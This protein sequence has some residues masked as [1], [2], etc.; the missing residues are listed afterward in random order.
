[1][2][3]SHQIFHQNAMTLL[4]SNSQ[5]LSFNDKLILVRNYQI[6]LNLI[7]K[8]TE[9]CKARACSHSNQLQIAHVYY[10]QF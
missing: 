1:M 10:L 3:K 5:R 7:T 2:K 9:V 6:N 8:L 4:N